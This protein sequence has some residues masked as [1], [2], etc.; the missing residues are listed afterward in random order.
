MTV[1]HEEAPSKSA[2]RPLVLA[3][4]IGVSVALLTVLIRRSDAPRI[5]EHIR[6]ASPAWL[7]AALGIYLLMILASAWRWGLLLGAQGVRVPVNR[8][9]ESFLVATFFNNFLPSNIGGDVVRVAD[10]AAAARSRTLAAAVVIADRGIG[11][12]GLV[13]LAAIAATMARWSEGMAEVVPWTGLWVLFFGAVAIAVPSLLAPGRTMRLLSP[14][15]A[16]HA[17]WVG[18]RLAQL[19][20]VLARFRE[21]PGPLL[22]CFAGAVVVQALL[23]AFYVAVARGVDVPVSP[24]H[25]AIVVPLSLLAQLLPISL[26]GFGVREAVFSYYFAQIGAPI[27]SALVVSLLGAGLIMVFSLSGALAYVLRGP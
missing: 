23:I 4:K 9:T 25:I 21:A 19:S 11:L 10:T 15:R 6:A 3:L 27:E 16:I 5:W 17:E 8:L 1:P 18:A 20:D 12:L 2:R 14:L 22:W 26:N 13:L 7:A 24:W